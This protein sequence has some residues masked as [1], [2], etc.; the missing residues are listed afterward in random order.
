MHQTMPHSLTAS[1]KSVPHPM[2]P[3]I[4]VPEKSYQ[5]PH[6]R[7][8]AYQTKEHLKGVSNGNTK[9]L[10]LKLLTARLQNMEDPAALVTSCI[11]EARAGAVDDRV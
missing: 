1:N 9:N 8:Q 2:P 6:L 10:H 4:S 5:N 7:T 11:D 3:D